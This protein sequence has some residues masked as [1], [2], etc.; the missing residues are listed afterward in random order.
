MGRAQL[1]LER[2]S[3]DDRA[4]RIIDDLRNVTDEIR[5]FRRE[6]NCV[7]RVVWFQAD[8]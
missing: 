4:G 7:S 5:P 2:Y 1:D 6:H 8:G 3:R